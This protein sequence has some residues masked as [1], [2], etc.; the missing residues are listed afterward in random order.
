M[1]DNNDIAMNMVMQLLRDPGIMRHLWIRA[2]K[3]LS[4]SE[5]CELLNIGE[6][7]LRGLIKEGKWMMIHGPSGRLEM[8]PNQFR[9]QRRIL[10]SMDKKR[11]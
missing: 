10:M 11:R 6:T 2:N 7:K 5:V 3:N 9:E 8:T 1:G 4:L